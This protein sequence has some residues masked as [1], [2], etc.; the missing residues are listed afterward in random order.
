M[1]TGIISGLAYCEE[2]CYEHFYTGFL[3]D[4]CVP[5]CGYTLREV[6]GQEVCISL[7]EI[8]QGGS[9]CDRPIYSPTSSV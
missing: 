5:V 3:V 4:M 1:S 6:L 8:L 7:V 9:C 2:C